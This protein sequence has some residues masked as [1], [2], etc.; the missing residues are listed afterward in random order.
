MLFKLGFYR[1]GFLKVGQM[2]DTQEATRGKGIRRGTIN[3]KEAIGGH[4][5]MIFLKLTLEILEL[6]MKK[7]T[8]GL[9]CFW[10]IFLKGAIAFLIFLKGAICK[11][12]WKPCYRQLGCK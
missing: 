3:S 4:L 9:V 7:K 6:Q 1:P 2:T 5:V 12:L 10:V 11:K 8:K